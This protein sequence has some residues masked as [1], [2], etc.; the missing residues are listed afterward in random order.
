MGLDEKP[1]GLDNI[2]RRVRVSIADRFAVR[3]VMQKV[4]LT[5]RYRREGLGRS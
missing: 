2:E 4:N 5:K 3:G 1:N